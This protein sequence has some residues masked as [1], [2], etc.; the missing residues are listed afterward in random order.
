MQTMYYNTRNFIRATDNIIDLSEYRRRLS[1]VTEPA[2]PDLPLA[3]WEAPAPRPRRSEERR[4]RRAMVME[5]L[6]S[7]AVM[8]ATLFVTVQFLG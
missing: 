3:A 5:L 7:A 8:A 1:A 2:E 4:Y 6:S